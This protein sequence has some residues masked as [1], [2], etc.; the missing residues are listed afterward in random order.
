[1]GASSFPFLGNKKK[2]SSC[3]RFRCVY[4]PLDRFS[5]V[6]SSSRIVDYVQAVYAV[7]EKK[8]NTNTNPHFR[9]SEEQRNEPPFLFRR[10]WRMFELVHGTKM[11]FRSCVSV[12][13]ARKR[14]CI[15]CKKK[16]SYMYISKVETLLRF[17]ALACAHA[18]KKRCSTSG[19]VTHQNYRAQ[20]VS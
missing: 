1:M 12:E 17:L 20:Q 5:F 4:C 7:H 8:K 6:A 10:C 2:T 9:V 14:I 19:N 16:K 13:K 3:S 15:V 11:L 18:E